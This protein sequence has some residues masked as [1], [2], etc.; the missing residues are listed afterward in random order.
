MSVGSVVEIR[1]TRNEDQEQKKR[2]EFLHLQD[3]ILQMYGVQSPSRMW[4]TLTLAPVLCLRNVTQTTV[5]IEWEPLQ[6]AHAD[7]LSLDV[8]RNGERIAKVPHPL[9]TTSTKLSGLSIDTEYAIQ[10]V[11]YT[12]AGTYVSEEVRT[13]TRTLDDMSGVHVCLGSLPEPPIADATKRLV[14]AMGAH[15][16]PKIELETTHLVCTATPA[17]NDEEQQKIYEKAQLLSLPIVQPHWLFACHDAQR[18]V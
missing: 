3:D 6:L 11:M 8:L 12:T 16:S 17:A 5:T 13:R 4:L 9:K 18:Y 10:L 7:L 2:E 15:W 14:E 1:V